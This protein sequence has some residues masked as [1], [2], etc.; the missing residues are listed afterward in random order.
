MSSAGKTGPDAAAALFPADG[1][2]DF[3]PEHF[4]ILQGV[5]AEAHLAA[6]DVD[7]GNGN[8]VPYHDSLVDLPGEYQHQRRSPACRP[9]RRSSGRACF[10]RLYC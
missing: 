7:D 6:A 5:N 8:I 4:H 9:R 2:K 3:P 10:V 1:V